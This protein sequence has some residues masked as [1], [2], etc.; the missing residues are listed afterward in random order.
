MN[1]TISEGQGFFVDAL[2]NYFDQE[3]SVTQDLRFGQD[4]PTGLKKCYAKFIMGMPL[5][6]NIQRTGKRIPGGGVAWDFKWVQAPGSCLSLKMEC[7]CMDGMPSPIPGTLGVTGP[8]P[9]PPN[10]IYIEV[11][12]WRHSHDNCPANPCD[13]G[14]TV[15]WPG[16]PPASYTVNFGMTTST[17]APPPQ[18]EVINAAANALK[19]A[20]E[21]EAQRQGKN[22]FCFRMPEA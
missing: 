16:C 4:P 15:T 11:T 20:M 8:L 14:W 19:G 7:H 1:L 21:G 6:K 13:G 17:S 22:F 3:P 12:W 2:G 5:V 10:N 9:L 18:R